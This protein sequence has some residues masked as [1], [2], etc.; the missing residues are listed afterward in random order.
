MVDPSR[1][2]LF[3]WTHP[4]W[5]TRRGSG[6]NHRPAANCRNCRKSRKGCRGSEGARRRGAGRMGR[7]IQLVESARPT[8]GRLVPAPS[9]PGLQGSGRR[10]PLALGRWPPTSFSR[11]VGFPLSRPALWRW[12]CSPVLTG[13][14]GAGC[15][16]DATGSAELKL[17]RVERRR[18]VFLVGGRRDVLAD[19]S[20]PRPWVH[21]GGPTDLLGTTPSEGGLQDCQMAKRP[22]ERAFP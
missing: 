8:G 9:G 19:G 14:T 20:P 10:A 5:A 18:L 1:E 6:L 13:C 4:R 17:L 15:S 22:S 12:P 7:R 2:G 16:V 11:P 21:S 3:G